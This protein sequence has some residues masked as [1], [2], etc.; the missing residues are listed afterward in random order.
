MTPLQQHSLLRG[1]NTFLPTRRFWPWLLLYGVVVAY[2]FPQYI[3]HLNPDGV[4]YMTL[5]QHYRRGLMDA[6]IN[7]YWSPLYTWLMIPLR[8]N[9]LTTPEAAQVVLVLAGG[10]IYYLGWKFLRHWGVRGFLL[11]GAMLTTGYAVLAMVYDAL[12]PDPISALWS[13]WIFW[14]LF[15]PKYGRG[16]GRAAGA[17]VLAG[18]A[19]LTKAFHLPYFL[20]V[21]TVWHLFLAWRA[22]KGDTGSEISVR[23]ALLRG[24]LTVLLL[25]FM[26]APWV[27]LISQKAGHFTIS[28]A[29]QY[30]SKLLVY[31]NFSHPHLE[32]GLVAPPFEQS[33]SAW[34]EI[35]QY[36]QLLETKPLS[37]RQWL[38]RYSQRVLLLS[39]KRIVFF[40]ED[41][42]IKWLVLVVLPLLWVVAGQRRRLNQRHLLL[43][44]ALLYAGSY[45][46]ILLEERYIWWVILLLIWLVFYAWGKLAKALTLPPITGA[47]MLGLGVI[48]LSMQ[49]SIRPRVLLNNRYTLNW[50]EEAVHV[51]LE[52]YGPEMKTRRVASEP[53]S[54]HEVQQIVF[55]Q[56]GQYYGTVFP[57]T[58]GTPI[59]EQLRAHDIEVFVTKWVPYWPFEWSFKRKLWDGYYIYDLEE[60]PDI[61]LPCNWFL[62]INPVPG[63]FNRFVF[64]SPRVMARTYGRRTYT[65]PPIEV[66]SQRRPFPW[67]DI[68]RARQHLRWHWRAK[69]FRQR[70]HEALKYGK[71]PYKEARRRNP[72]FRLR[73]LPLEVQQYFRSPADSARNEQQAPE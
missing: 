71:R 34:D 73:T 41:W 13:L 44:A 55:R 21:F 40:L 38:E 37:T 11:V 56:E 61:V 32:A 7:T 17:G 72:Y 70:W 64:G 57:D 46:L 30:N 66:T 27:A 43:L 20:L 50:E 14:L 63:Y 59:I 47:A 8:N 5:V 25:L 1:G 23:G 18:V 35:T 51:W 54:W 45:S 3:M 62:V 53:G 42:R 15:H 10:G 67:W 26:A 60:P 2:T 69:S 48:V 9:K 22:R 39:W 58:A 36:P 33:T 24:G 31:W 16:Y 28:T 29:G 4:S 12:T 19:Y 52:R 6:A 65:P 49:V 68:D